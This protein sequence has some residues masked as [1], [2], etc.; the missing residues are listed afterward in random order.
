MF[1]RFTEPARNAVVLA[2]DE[3]RGLGHGHIGSEH[4][5]LGL[6]GEERGLAM[7]VLGSLGVTLE[8]ARA[9]VEAVVGRGE[10]MPAGQIPFTPEAKKSL[11]GALHEAQDLGHEHIGTEH[12]LL[13]L[14]DAG[15][16]TVAARVLADLGVSADGLH[17]EVLGALGGGE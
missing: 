14:A 9:R 2:Q 6:A 16:E 8:G 12:L 4:L 17:A 13:G 1:T 3:A 15:A 11:E 10:G 7:T 5:L